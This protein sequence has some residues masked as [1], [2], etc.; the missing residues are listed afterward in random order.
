MAFDSLREYVSSL[1]RIGELKRITAPVD[2]VHELG[3]IA[4]VSLTR[5]EPALMFENV[6]GY[7]TPILTNVLST[8]KKMAVALGVEG[9]MKAIFEK[10]L[11]LAKP[12]LNTRKNDIH[13]EISSGGMPKDSTLST[14]DRA[15][16]TDWIDSL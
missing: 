7:K 11:L 10:I 13:T 1:E 3:A 15:K 16:I 8:D 2:P 5:K 4:Y 12:Y 14:E 6:K 9:D